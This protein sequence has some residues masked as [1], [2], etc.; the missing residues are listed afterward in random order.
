MN[1]PIQQWMGVRVCNAWNHSDGCTC[2]FGGEGHLGRRSTSVPPPQPPSTAP[3][4]R[5]FVSFTIPNARCPV[6]RAL[7]FFYQSLDGGRVFFDD[8]GP[9][10]P[11]HPC[12]DR[13]RTSPRSAAYEPFE[14]VPLV[15]HTMK[16]SPAWAK[17]GWVPFV[18]DPNGVSVVSP[19]NPHGSIRGQMGSQHMTLHV[20]TSSLP[21]D[22][23]FHVRRKEIGCYEVSV[24]YMQRFHAAP[25]VKTYMAFTD[26]IRAGEHGR[27]LAQ[28]DKRKLQ[29]TG[30]KR[31]KGKRVFLLN[32]NR[33]L[34]CPSKVKS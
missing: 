27:K 6:C 3:R 7:V 33:K 30:H 21:K 20:S 16:Q 10:W 26:P 1:V 23:L 22:G 14:V 34:G 9:P 2:G 19:P 5:S 24:A 17:A 12:T 8:L 13:T 18:C 31:A 32:G 25:L 4:Y 29:M 15:T 11:K 28:R